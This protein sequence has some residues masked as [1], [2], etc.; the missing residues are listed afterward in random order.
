MQILMSVRKTDVFVCLV[1]V[2][3]WP[4][5]TD[6]CVTMAT[7]M[8]LMAVFVLM[9]M[10]AVKQACVN[11]DLVLIWMAPSNVYVSLATLSP[12]PAKPVWVS[13]MIPVRHNDIIVL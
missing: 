4:G 12:H 11:M 2:R 6:V 7:L 5:A 10:S 8:L 3:T 1:G 9:L 13:D